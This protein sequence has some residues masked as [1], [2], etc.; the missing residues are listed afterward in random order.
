MKE[1]NKYDLTL[2]SAGWML[3]AVKEIKYYFGYSVRE[4]LDLAQN[5]PSTLLKGAPKE[6]AEKLKQI[7]EG[8]GATVELKPSQD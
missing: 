5:V 7:L 1:N 2:L 8:I 6:E 4:S 3:L